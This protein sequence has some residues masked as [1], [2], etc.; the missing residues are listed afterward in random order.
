S[1]SSTVIQSLAGAASRIRRV[2]V[3]ESRP[4]CEARATAEILCD[5]GIDVVLICDAAAAHAMDLC[6]RVFVG[7]DTFLPD[8]SVV[9]KMGTTPIALAARDRGVPFHAVGTTYKCHLDPEPVVLEEGEGAA[10]THGLS[11]VRGWNILFERTRADLIG[12]R[13]SEQG[14]PSAPGEAARIEALRRIFIDIATGE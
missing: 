12:E 4:E 13:V 2:Y 7:V 10:L 5:H 9:N 8:G 11:S 6:Q 3:T 14:D 1:Y